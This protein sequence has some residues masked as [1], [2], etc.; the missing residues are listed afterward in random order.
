MS[1][2]VPV[3][4]DF[5]PRVLWWH[6]LT[7]QTVDELLHV[8]R[9]VLPPNILVREQQGIRP[10]R[11]PLLSVYNSTC[12]ALARPRML[13]DEKCAF[14]IG[15]VRQSEASGNLALCRNGKSGFFLKEAETSP[16]LILTS[17][18][19]PEQETPQ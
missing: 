13:T 15:Y 5:Q 19:S 12:G 10:V 6:E 17:F 16:I 9:H 1:E 4:I 7:A 2:A 3:R 18:S 8:D 14:P 11:T